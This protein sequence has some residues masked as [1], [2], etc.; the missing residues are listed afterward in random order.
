MLYKEYRCP[1]CNKLLFKGL[2]VDSEVEVKC[3]GCSGLNMFHGEAKEKL[4]C[5][6]ENC[7]NRKS[8]GD[9]LKEGK[10]Q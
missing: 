10:A 6:K 7:P 2:L 3:R 5:F 8:R 9:V 1:S 4:L